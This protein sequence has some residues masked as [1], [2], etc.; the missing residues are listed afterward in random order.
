MLEAISEEG[1]TS[2]KKRFFME[3]SLNQQDGAKTAFRSAQVPVVARETPTSRSVC[4]GWDGGHCPG[5]PKTPKH[6]NYP[7]ALPSSPRR[8]SLRGAVRRV[9]AWTVR[10]A[11]AFL[12][13][14]PEKEGQRVI[15]AATLVASPVSSRRAGGRLVADL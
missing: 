10:L 5:C 12:R 6:A 13:G 1:F 7:R 4:G 14:D 2:R 8:G 3:S 15:K 9:C 11:P